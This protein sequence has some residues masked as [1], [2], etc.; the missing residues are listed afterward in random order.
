LK[1]ESESL[2]KA[3]GESVC[4]NNLVKTL[5]KI[6]QASQINTSGN[7]KNRLQQLTHE[8]IIEKIA[9][10]WFHKTDSVIAV[11]EKGTALGVKAAHK[12]VYRIEI[13]DYVYYVIGTEAD[14]IRK[15]EPH[16]STPENDQEIVDQ[17]TEELKKI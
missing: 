14:V 12:M 6:V 4:M 17:L 11:F 13:D 16:L 3:Y 8:T 15:I 5:K 2:N 7:I 10:G 9:D 1:K